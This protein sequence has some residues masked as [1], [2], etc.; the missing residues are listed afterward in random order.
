MT[1]P[2]LYAFEKYWRKHPPTHLLVAGFFGYKGRE[3]EEESEE[4][5]LDDLIGAFRD[6]GLAE[7]K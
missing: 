6:A 4:A 5:S 1:L 2:R 7:K 3:I